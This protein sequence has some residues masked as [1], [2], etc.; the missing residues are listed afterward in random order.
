MAPDQK[1]LWVRYLPLGM[2][3]DPLRAAPWRKSLLAL[4]LAALTLKARTNTCTRLRP[5][6]FK[7]FI[8]SHKPNSL[9]GTSKVPH[10]AQDGRHVVAVKYKQA[11]K[12][13]SK[14]A[15]QSI[16][17]TGEEA[18]SPRTS[19]TADSR[20]DTSIGRRGETNKPVLRTRLSPRTIA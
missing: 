20:N 9:K 13:A 10:L 2:A 14:R 12:Q 17:E 6:L 11:S 19:E 18:T 3:P 8:D 15:D 4:H 7:P 1:L 16:R 5:R